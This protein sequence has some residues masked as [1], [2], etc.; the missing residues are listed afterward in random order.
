MVEQN[1]SGFLE[2]VRI[3]AGLLCLLAMRE[4]EKQLLT[5]AGWGSLLLSGSVSERLLGGSTIRADGPAASQKLIIVT[6]S[7]VSDSVSERIISS[8]CCT[9]VKRCASCISTALTLLLPSGSESEKMDLRSSESSSQSGTGLVAAC[10]EN[11][12]LI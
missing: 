8:E 10:S 3:E 9:V 1:A 12:S 2:L 5:G 7:L 11:A 4:G 6:S